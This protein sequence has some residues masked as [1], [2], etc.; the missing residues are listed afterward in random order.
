MGPGPRGETLTIV[1]LNEHSVKIALYISVSTQISVALR[2]HKKS[3]CSAWCLTKKL[4]RVKLQRITVIEMLTHNGY[5]YY[6]QHKQGSI[7]DEGVKRF[8]NKRKARLKQCLLTLTGP[9][10]SR[11]QSTY[12]IKPVSILA[13]RGERLRISPHIT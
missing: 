10:D 13:W 6:P 12:K 3:L 1:L 8:K 2:T 4:T 9:L 11:T 7:M 5:L